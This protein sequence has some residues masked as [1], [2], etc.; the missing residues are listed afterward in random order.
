M[1]LFSL[2]LGATLA[3]G[4]VLVVGDAPG[5]RAEG[6]EETPLEAPPT[7]KPKPPAKKD[8]NERGSAS[9]YRT[10]RALAAAHRTLPFGTK[11]K[12]STDKGRSVIVTITGRGP[13]IKGRIIDLSSDAFKTLASLGTGI[14][15]VTLQRIQ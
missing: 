5:A 11:V 15:R 6:E 1:R 7:P 8:T 3:F 2:L 13:F 9:W 10:K 4:L 12:V 14:L